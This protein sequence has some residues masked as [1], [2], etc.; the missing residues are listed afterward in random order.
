MKKLLQFVGLIAL[1]L[2]TSHC[3]TIVRG[4]SQDFTT[5][6]DPSGARI[7]VNDED[8]GTTPTTL[9]LKR[10]RSH[11]IVFRLDGYEDVTVNLDRKFMVGWPIFGNIFSFGLIG[12]VVDVANGSAYQLT[13]EELDVTLRRTGGTAS[14]KAEEDHIQVFFFTHDQVRMALGK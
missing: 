3:A 12:I 6:S 14:I 11:K 8:K 13:P 9:T 7:L 5:N 4:T 10:N 2:I 1:V